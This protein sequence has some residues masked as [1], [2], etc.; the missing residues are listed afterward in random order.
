MSFGNE[1]SVCDGFWSVMDA[2]D[3][4]LLIQVISNYGLFYKRASI[5]P[6]WKNLLASNEWC[7]VSAYLPSGIFI[8]ISVTKPR[9]DRVL[10][11]VFFAGQSAKQKF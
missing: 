7:G 1:F 5:N 6:G 8:I 11:R 2:T 3:N 9:C 4:K 10:I